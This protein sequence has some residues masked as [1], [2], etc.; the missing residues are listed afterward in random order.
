MRE[1]K[2]AAELSVGILPL[3][4]KVSQ[5]ECEAIGEAFE[6]AGFRL[7]PF[8]EVCDIYVINTCT[9]TAESDAKSRKAIRRAIKKNPDALVMVSGCYSQTSPD[10]VAKIEGVDVVIGN[11]KKMDLP[12]I[13]RDI[14]ENK[15]TKPYIFTQNIDEA[16]FEP[17]CITRAPR[18]RAYVKIEDGCECR[19]SYCAIPGARGRVRSKPMVDVIEEVEALARAGTAEVVL[20]GIETA[21]YGADLGEGYGLIDL[22]EA[23]DQRKS[24]RRIR[25]GSLSPE[26]MREDFVNRLAR[27]S[28][29]V[30]HFHLSMQ[31]GSDSVLRG[32]RRRYNTDMALAA[33]QRLRKGMPSV[34]FTTDMMVGFPGEGETEFEE[35]LAFVRKA[36]FLDMHVFA[37][38]RR[39]NTPAASYPNQV[40]E[41]EKHR[42]SAALIE[43]KNRIR[44]EILDELVKKGETLSVVVETVKNGIACAHA[45]N[46]VELR[47]SAENAKHGEV[48]DV[49]PL[50]HE[51]GIVLAKII[52]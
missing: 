18:T 39:K 47:F 2:G 26:K 11:H 38:S 35:T 30:P 42:R 44:D 41:E 14:I 1:N 33:L 8:S 29:V 50:S 52:K 37:Y 17:M 22:L 34:Q 36:R 3:G 43:E 46:F 48:I 23:L 15:Q 51:D 9:V 16:P 13:A 21:S 27:L 4:C 5:Y 7:L 12:S 20:T 10:E 45:E 32:M 6:K 25:L 40:S 49:L 24:C 28:I 19:C 31:S